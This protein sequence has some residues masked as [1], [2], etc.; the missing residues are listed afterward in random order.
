MNW[1]DCSTASRAL[2]E[3]GLEQGV[4]GLQ[5]EHGDGCGVVPAPRPGLGESSIA[6]RRAVHR[7]Q[8]EVH[9][10]ADLQRDL[11][12]AP[13]V[14]SGDGGSVPLR[15]ACAKA[16]ISA[17]SGSAFSNCCSVDSDLRHA[18]RAQAH[19]LLAHAA[20]VEVLAVDGD[21]LVGLEDAQLAQRQSG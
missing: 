19:A 1:V 2:G 11:Q 18:P 3:L 17:I 8:G 6:C 9:L 12:R 15:T 10:P 4:L 13:A 21:V 14:R 16:R 5:V 20:H 7:A